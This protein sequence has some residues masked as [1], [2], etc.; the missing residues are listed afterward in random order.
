MTAGRI[1][2]RYY[3]R[4]TR[5][6]WMIRYDRF[7]II[8]NKMI[9]D[10][11]IYTYLY[12]TILCQVCIDRGFPDFFRILWTT[13]GISSYLFAIRMPPSNVFDHVTLEQKFSSTVFTS[14]PHHP[15]MGIFMSSKCWTAFELFGTLS[16]LVKFFI[17]M[18]TKM[19]FQS[20]GHGKFFPTMFTFERLVP[21]MLF[22]AMRNFGKKK[23][24]RFILDV[25][26]QEINC[27]YLG[28]KYWH[29]VGHK[30]HIEKAFHDLFHGMIQDVELN[31]A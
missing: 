28:S 2:F 21:C 17:R 22:T 7:T 16:T 14:M 15:G 18:Y 13:D 10:R 19:T 3:V 26:A 6:F 27:S 30:Y 25:L 29:N 20:I 8:D 23:I 5:D 11:I 1:H 12:S 9:L 24:W 31:Y 4:R